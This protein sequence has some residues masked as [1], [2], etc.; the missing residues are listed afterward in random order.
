MRSRSG[1]CCRALLHD[2]L[3]LLALPVDVEHEGLHRFLRCLNLQSDFTLCVQRKY[4]SVSGAFRDTHDLL[5]R[6]HYGAHF[7]VPDRGGRETHA[8]D[9]A[10]D[11]VVQFGALNRSTK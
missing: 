4:H 1:L 5:H 11:H 10:A 6:L 9:A 3:L 8:R 2:H 7:Q